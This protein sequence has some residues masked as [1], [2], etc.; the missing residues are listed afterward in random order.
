MTDLGCVAALN[1]CLGVEKQII[2]EQV[3][4]QLP[5]KFKVDLKPPFVLSGAIVDVNPRTGLAVSIEPVRVV[6]DLASAI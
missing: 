1:S 2:I 6:D 4:T 3:M 5:A